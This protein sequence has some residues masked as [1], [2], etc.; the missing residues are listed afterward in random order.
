[1]VKYIIFISGFIMSN[2]FIQESLYS[3]TYIN[4]HMEKSTKK[5]DDTNTYGYV[6]GNA[7]KNSLDNNI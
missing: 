3:L 6:L 4:S 2:N 1:M 5:R 7:L